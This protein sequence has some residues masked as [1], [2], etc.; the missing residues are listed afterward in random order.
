MRTL[1]RNQT[2]IWVVPRA[3]SQDVVD[4]EGN[5]TGERTTT[6]GATVETYL[7]MYPSDG[8]MNNRSFGTEK[9]FDMVAVSN[10]L[11]LNE[12]DLIFLSEPVSD[13]DKTYDYIVK[14][15]MGS[16]NTNQYGLKKRV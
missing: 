5:Y 16:L 11:T 7:S 6:Y 9:S 13:Y 15:D 1:T 10:S 4:G 14:K 8:N 3:V 12:K 2:K